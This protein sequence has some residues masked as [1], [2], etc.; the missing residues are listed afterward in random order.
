MGAFVAEVVRIVEF[1]VAA[2]LAAR[3]PAQPQ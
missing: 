3:R 1:A 2:V